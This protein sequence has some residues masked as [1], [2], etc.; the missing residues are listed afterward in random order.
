MKNNKE[1]LVKAIEKK[2]GAGFT[3]G[4]Y[5]ESVMDKLSKKELDKVIASIYGDSTDVDVQ[6]RRKPYVVEVSFVDNEVDFVAI[7]REEY[8]RR[9]GNERYED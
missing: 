3:I 9:Y 4:C 7:T 8:I 1:T 2:L 6:I 5:T